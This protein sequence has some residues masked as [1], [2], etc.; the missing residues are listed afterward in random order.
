MTGKQENADVILMEI[1]R[2]LLLHGA[3][4]LPDEK[5]PKSYNSLVSDHSS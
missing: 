1:I 3:E 4:E 2:K 5:N